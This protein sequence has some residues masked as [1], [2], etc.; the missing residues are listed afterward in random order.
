LKTDSVAKITSLGALD[1][2]YVEIGTGTKD[3]P[4]AP[5]G[6]EVKSADAIGIGDLGGMIGN[7][8]PIAQQALQS[9]NQRLTELQVTVAR[10]NELL[11]DKNR[12]NI[13]ASLGNLNA[14]LAEDRPKLSA[15]L[16]NV[17]TASA[18]IVPLLDNLKTTMNQAN[19]ALSHVDSV[20]VENREDLRTIV[21]E[22]KGTL[23][24]A[25]SLMEQVQNMA[26]HNTGNIDDILANLRD[27]TENM[28]QLTDTL[29]ARP[30]MLIRGNTVKDRI[31]GERAAD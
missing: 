18:K 6:S 21:V 12:E 8:A 23:L 7:L 27:T 11:N 3:A 20:L 28:R 16:T 1:E 2:N 14:M 5:P 31:P 24:T 13:S 4:L 26:D 25:S 19:V 9:L 22:L 29:K 10:V 15:S 17:Q 30:S